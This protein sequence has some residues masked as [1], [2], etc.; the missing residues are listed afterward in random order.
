MDAVM[1]RSR[2]PCEHADTTGSLGMPQVTAGVLAPLANPFS[3]VAAMSTSCS[4]I[5]PMRLGEPTGTVPK[6]DA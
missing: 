5:S 4:P 3:R 2:R 1:I 6:G